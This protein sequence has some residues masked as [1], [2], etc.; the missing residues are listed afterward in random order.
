MTYRLLPNALHFSEFQGGFH[1]TCGETALATAMV[2][3]TPPIEDTQEAIDL[4]LSMTH[5]LIGLGWASSSGSTTTQHLRDEAVRRGFSPD[6]SSFISFQQPLANSAAFHNLL[7]STAGVKPIVIEIAKAGVLEG[8]S[9]QYHFICVVGITDAGYICNDGDNPNISSHLVT[10]SWAQLESAV[11]CGVLVLDMKTSGGS[12]MPVPA[13]WSDNGTTLKDPSGKIVTLGFRQYILDNAWDAA[14]VV[15]TSDKG[16]SEVELA[17]S[18]HGA[19]DIQYFRYSQ[20]SYTQKEGVFKTWLGSEAAW[21]RD[22]IGALSQQAASKDAEISSLESQIAALQSQIAA[23]KSQPTSTVDPSVKTAL[24]AALQL[25]QP[26]ATVASDL[27]AALKT[28][29]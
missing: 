20:L 27:Q 4:M 8:N 25:V 26:S 21:M 3:S 17:N 16:V 2:C 29:P 12:A 22:Q 11:P 10:Y 24:S 5:E 28:L 13:G 14:D 19:G 7:L 1:G 6:S 9:V 18:S 15:V 23:L